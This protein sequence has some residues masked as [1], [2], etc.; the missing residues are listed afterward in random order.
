M[1]QDLPPVTSLSEDAA[2]Q[3]Q[4]VREGLQVEEGP[5]AAGLGP[6]VDYVT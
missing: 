5:K 2:F 1:P 4:G 6:L 3:H